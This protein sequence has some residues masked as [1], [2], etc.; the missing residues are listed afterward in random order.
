MPGRR[1]AHRGSG[2]LAQ[3]SQGTDEVAKSAVELAHTLQPGL[4]LNLQPLQ[5]QARWGQRRGNGAFAF[6]A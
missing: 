5:A 6:A 4:R 1:P 3:S 2:G